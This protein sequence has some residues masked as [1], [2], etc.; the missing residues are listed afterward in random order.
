MNMRDSHF[1]HEPYP[2]S[3]QKSQL[4]FC[5]VPFDSSF[6]F[7]EEPAL[8]CR[9]PVSVMEIQRKIEEIRVKRII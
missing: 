6:I 3:I 9:Q 2:Q 8:A 7:M 1:I 5:L 4:F